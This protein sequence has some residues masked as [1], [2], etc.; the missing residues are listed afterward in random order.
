MLD[1]VVVG[2]GTTVSWLEASATG[3]STEE[4]GMFVEL[5]KF[6]SEGTKFRSKL[7]RFAWIV[8]A[9]TNRLRADHCLISRMISNIVERDETAASG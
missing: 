6:V 1:G 8:F 4:V 5:K 9:C 7:S 2:G 3:E